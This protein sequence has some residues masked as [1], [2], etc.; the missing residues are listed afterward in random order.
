MFG[1]YSFSDASQNEPNAIETT[2]NTLAT[3]NQSVTL[4]ETRIFSPSLLNTFRFGFSRAKI[5]DET[6]PLIPQLTDPALA[7]VPGKPFGTFDT[8]GLVGL[9]V[10]TP[11]K[12]IHN[13]FQWTDDL[14]YQKGSNS[15]KVGANIQRFRTNLLD[16]GEAFGR[17]RFD[18]LRDM[19]I[20]R[21]RSFDSVIPGFEVETSAWRQS[22]FGFFAQDDLR[23]KANLTVNLGLRYEFITVPRDEQGDATLRDLLHDS[24]VTVGPIFR[25]PSLKNIA[26]RVGLAWNPMGDQKTT[27][28]AGFGIFY[29][30]VV[31]RVY[32]VTAPPPFKLEGQLSRPTLPVSAT[33]LD[34]T[35]A[36]IRLNQTYY[37]ID[38]PTKLRYSLSI[39]RELPGQTVLSVGY[40][41]SRGYHQ[42][43]L[44]DEFNAAIPAILPDGRKFFAPNLPRRNPAWSN[45]RLR[46]SDATMDYNSLLLSVNKRFSGGLQFQASYTLSKNITTD[47]LEVANPELGNSIL[48]QDTD[49]VQSNRGLSSFDIR[50]NLVFNYTYDLPFGQGWWG[51]WQ[52]GGIATFSSGNPLTPTLGFDNARQ[53]TRSGGG[54]QRPDLVSGADKNPILGGPDKYFDDSVFTLPPAGFFGNLGKN[55][56]IGPGLA[57]FDFSLNKITR[58]GESRSLQFR[59]EFFNFTNHPNFSTPARIVFDSRGRVGSAGRITSTKTTGRQIQFGLKFLF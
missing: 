2:L 7:F 26:P 5:D 32:K 38:T 6:L 21:T 33:Q 35:A 57:T 1:R 12:R 36:I 22:M 30:Q 44:L 3:R 56:L 28:R 9:G 59:A 48:P 54:G 42:F 37:N 4:E 46:F 55:T 27:V 17:L 19:L 13:V 39:Q 24:Q 15:L 53:L 8:T 16:P 58:L 49:D 29:D 20:G 40:T 34:P 23:L 52:I 50:H 47:D 31:A 11:T 25:N 18:S 41:G 14:T 51:G 10:S 43:R 45:I